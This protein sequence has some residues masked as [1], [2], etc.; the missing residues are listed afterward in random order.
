M[1]A[2]DCRGVSHA[3][4]HTAV[5]TGVDLSVAEGTEITIVPSIAGGR[6]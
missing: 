6:S 2:L 1:T 3:Y 4:G 5:L